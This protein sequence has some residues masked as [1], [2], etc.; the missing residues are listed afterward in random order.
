MKKQ[1]HL[2][3]PMGG[4]GSRFSKNG[5][6]LPK[7]LLEIHN[8]PFFYWAIQSIKKFVPLKSLTCVVLQEHIDQ[9]QIDQKIQ[10]YFPETNIVIIPQVLNGA[11]LTCMEGIKNIPFN[12]P[13]L[14]NDC[15]HA[16]LSRSFYNF[17]LNG[18][19]DYLDGALLSFE[20]TEPKFSYLECDGNNRVMR[21]VEK[22]P[23]STHAICGAYY[24][25]NTTIF[26]TA[27]NEYLSRCNYSEYYISGV[28]NELIREN[29][30]IGYFELDKHI[31]FG[32]PDEY[33]TAEKIDDFEEFL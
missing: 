22:N 10:A 1:L 6:I 20:S 25:K 27:V 2:I 19:F 9:F 29:R 5:Y 4:Y 26:K 30:N 21:T 14:F 7:P 11:V 18:N 13:I 15:D 23:I 32:T 33:K 8:K 28:Y 17:C 3:M 31:T 12:E 16:F 24:F